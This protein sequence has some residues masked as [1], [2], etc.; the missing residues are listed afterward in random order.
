M[1]FVNR[2]LK[3][4]ERREYVLKEKVKDYKYSNYIAK[5]DSGTIDKENPD[6]MTTNR[7]VKSVVVYFEI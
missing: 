3:E 6:Q 5:F 1:R 4:N 7:Y 2:E